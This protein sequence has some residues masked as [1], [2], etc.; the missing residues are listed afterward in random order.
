MPHDPVNARRDIVEGTSAGQHDRVILTK[1]EQPANDDGSIAFD[2]H[3]AYDEWAAKQVMNTLEQHYP[4]HLFRVIHD[5]KQGVCL[6]SIPI[7]MGINKFMAINLKTHAMDSHRAIK[8]GGEILE[9]YNLLRGR[10]DSASFLEARD[11]HSILVD[12]SRVVPG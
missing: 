5:S 4:G 3:Q 10:F 6:I 11:K 9:R 7:L 8:A 12:R 1:R 2:P